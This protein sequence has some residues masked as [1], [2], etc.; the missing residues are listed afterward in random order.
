MP[1]RDIDLTEHFDRFVERQVS[2]GR[3]SNASEIVP[4]VWEVGT[5]SHQRAIWHAWGYLGDELFRDG[6]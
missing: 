2:S 1:T 3:C 4:E 6:V 5:M